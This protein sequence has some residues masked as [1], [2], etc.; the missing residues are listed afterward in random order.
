MSNTKRKPIDKTE[1]IFEM[2]HRLKL[3][4]KILAKKHIDVKPIK[5]L[6]K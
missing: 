5:F 2:E 1:S 4:A 3:E 6:I